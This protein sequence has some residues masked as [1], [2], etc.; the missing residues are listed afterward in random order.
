MAEARQLAVADR[1][2]F[3][4]Q[5]GCRTPGIL[6]REQGIAIAMVNPDW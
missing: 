4:P 5:G 3:G 1:C 2:T 6:H